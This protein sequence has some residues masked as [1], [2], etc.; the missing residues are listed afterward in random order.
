MSTLPQLVEARRQTSLDR[1]SMIA[2]RFNDPNSPVPT[3]QLE[4]EQSLEDA[5][6]YAEMA[7][8][9]ESSMRRGAGPYSLTGAHSF[10]GDL[11]ASRSDRAAR[12]R[13]ERS[14][15]TNLSSLG[16]EARDIGT[17]AMGGAVVPQ[18]LVDA[19][20]PTATAGRPLADAIGSL[21]LP[22]VGMSVVV[23]R[24]TTPGAAAALASETGAVSSTDF[25]LTATTAPVC[26][27]VARLTVSRAVFDRGRRGVDLMIA[28]EISDLVNAEKD[29]LLIVGSGTSGQPAGLLNIAGASATTY[30]D[31]TP[32][33]PELVRKLAANATTASLARRRPVEAFLMHSR[34]WY[35]LASE[36]SAGSS[37]PLPF[38]P[39]SVLGVPVILDD[40][41]PVNLGAGT[42]E[43]RVLA[44]RPSDFRLYESPIAVAVGQTATTSVDIVVMAFFAAHLGRYPAGIGIVS[45]TGLNAVAV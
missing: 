34:R 44:I 20:A 19:V 37:T 21:P 10:F 38:G 9:L 41:V 28:S 22:E 24:V 27:I 11:V 30:T 14:Q 3:L 8:R 6:R 17:S 15:L 2:K 32:T 7:D 40:N 42:D 39:R 45:G 4:L 1:A 13:L 33:T 31:G 18:F 35:W 26:A 5:E 29:R 23:G 36:F 25:A 12:E 43:D 16:I